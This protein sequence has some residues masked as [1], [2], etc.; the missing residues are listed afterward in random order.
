MRYFRGCTVILFEKDSRSYLTEKRR[1][2]Q[3]GKSHKRIF[4]KFQNSFLT[5]RFGD[6]QEVLGGGFMLA[7]RG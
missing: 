1:I 3:T 2:A 7:G 5:K 4:E 6:E